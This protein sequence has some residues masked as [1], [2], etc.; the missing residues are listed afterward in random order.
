MNIDPNKYLYICGNSYMYIYICIH[1]NA[2]KNII[3]RLKIYTQKGINR[4]KDI[5]ASK[6]NRYT[7]DTINFYVCP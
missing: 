2:C 7:L 4:G 3:D 5:C 6:N 1:K